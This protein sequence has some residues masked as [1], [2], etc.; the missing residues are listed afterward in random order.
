M[1]ASIFDDPK[2]IFNKLQLF[3][4]IKN[5]IICPLSSKTLKNIEL[6]NQIVMPTFIIVIN[7]FKK[8]L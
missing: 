2:H 1:L 4:L 6:H 3:S 7:K 8:M 5:I